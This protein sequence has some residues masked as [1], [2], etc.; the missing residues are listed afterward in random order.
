MAASLTALGEGPTVAAE[1]MVGLACDL[2]PPAQKVKHEIE[3]IE[4]EG[5]QPVLPPGKRSRQGSESSGAL[6]SSSQKLRKVSP[7]ATWPW[8]GGSG[9]LSCPQA[10]LEGQ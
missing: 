9:R 4:E 6:E 8:G 2:H 3:T 5:G 1:V 7:S 10:P